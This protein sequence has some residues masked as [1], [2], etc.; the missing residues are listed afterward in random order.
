MT[1][2]VTYGLLTGILVLLVLVLWQANTQVPQETWERN[3]QVGIAAYRQGNYG[4]A[5]KQTE[6]ALEAAKAFGP[7]DL[8]LANTLNIL[9]SL[10]HAQGKYAEAEPLHKRALAIREKMLGP[11][12]PDLALSLNNLAM[13]Y[14]DLGKYSEA[15]PLHKRALAIWEKALGPNHPYVATG[16]ENYALLLRKTERTSE[17]E[18][19]GARAKAI[20]ASALGKAVKFSSN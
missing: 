20:R 4:E 14:H 6:A 9:A 19:V 8:R 3:Y 12:H 2:K 10:Y 18:N 15:E 7:D 11:E 16:L 1:K 13:L 17:A 5:V